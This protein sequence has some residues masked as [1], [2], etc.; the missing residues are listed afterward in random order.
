[1]SFQLSSQSIPTSFTQWDWTTDDSSAFLSLTSDQVHIW[2]SPLDISPCILPQ[3]HAYLSEDEQDRA[4][5]FHFDR[6]RHH[7][8]VGRGVLR[9]L[10]GKYVQQNPQDLRFEY[11]DR[12]KPYLQT[13]A[14]TEPNV[15]S[16][17]SQRPLGSQAR[18]Q[19]LQFNVSHSG[20]VALYAIALNR[21]VGIDLEELRPMSNAAQLAKRFFTDREY[22]QLL[23]QPLDQQTLAFFRGWT[24]KEAYL[25]ATGEGLSGLETVEVSLLADQPRVLDG[26][27]DRGDPFIV[28]SANGV[29]LSKSIMQWCIYDIPLATNHQAAVVIEALDNASQLS[30]NFFEIDFADGNLRNGTFRMA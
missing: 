20:G 24:R 4:A 7:F 26:V 19:N 8:I 2:R 12:G 1:M 3:L 10:L 9:V 18:P 6:H 14:L 22:A 13:P 15:R 27:A 30:M 5:R 17:G 11:G 28:P 29:S 16:L 23:S 21:R 25:K